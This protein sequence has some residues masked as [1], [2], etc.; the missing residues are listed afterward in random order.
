MDAV[1]RP[2]RGTETRQKSHVIPFRVNDAERAELEAAAS[3]AG[4][5]VGSYIRGRVLAAPT[6]RAMRRPSVEVET[7]A[8]LQGE[9]NKVGSNIHQL[10]K[11]VNFGETP[12][13]VELREAFAGYREVIAAIL[14]TLGR[15]A[16]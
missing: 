6:T 9:M 3:R 10:V 12:A 13:G 8:R 15:G 7:L 4:L 5:T 1:K 16:R 14:A 11:R 2:R